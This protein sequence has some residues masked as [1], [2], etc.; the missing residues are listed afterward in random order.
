MPRKPQFNPHTLV[1][2]LEIRAAHAPQS[3]P[4]KDKNTA[5]TTTTLI[6]NPVST[7]ESAVTGKHD[8]AIRHLVVQPSL[9]DGD[10]I[11][12]SRTAL[13]DSALEIWNFVKESERFQLKQTKLTLHLRT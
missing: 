4:G 12:G 2:Q 13:E 8:C 6:R 1:P 11:R 3:I 9:G 7:K 10:D 5:A